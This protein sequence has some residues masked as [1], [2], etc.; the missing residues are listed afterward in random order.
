MRSGWTLMEL[1]IA[2]AIVALV[3][4]A[5]LINF[6]TQINKGFDA[7]RKADLKAIEKAF[8]EYYNDNNCYP[9]ITILDNCGGADLNPYLKK[10]PCD[11]VTKLPY[12]YV[13][14]EQG[15]CKGFRILTALSVTSDPDI[16]LA[17]CSST[18]GCGY[19]GTG[20]NWGISSGVTVANPNGIGPTPTPTIAPTPTPT[21][22]PV[23][24][25]YACPPGGG[26]CNVYADPMACNPGPCCP[27]SFTNLATCNAAC[28]NPANRCQN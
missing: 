13:L 22:T 4:L 19:F 1:L 9:P 17:G 11:P 20:Y 5:L 3:S 7:R 15:Q 12:K 10:I 8:E 16:V 27:I 28:A 6:R 25:N 24:G 23:P 26:S 18:Y 2:V 21:P 14:A